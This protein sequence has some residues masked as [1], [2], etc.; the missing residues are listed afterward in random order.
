[1]VVTCAD[2]LGAEQLYEQRRLPGAC[3][4]TYGLEEYADVRAANLVALNGSQYADLHWWHAPK[5]QLMLRVPGAHNVRNALATLAVANWCGVSFQ[6]ALNSLHDFS[7]TA[8]RFEYKGTARGVTV[9][10]DY[11]HHPTKVQATLDAARHRYPG[12]RIWAVFQPHTY[13]RTKQLLAEFAQSFAA[14]DQVIVTD[15]YAAREADDGSVNA[16][17]VVA[18]SPHPH[19]QYIGGLATVADYLAEQIRSG[20]IVVIMGA[21]DS[22]RI[23]EM[24]LERL[25]RDA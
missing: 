1:L 13:S 3:W 5:G 17:D 15:I 8:R 4:I 16:Q 9:I 7:G 25:K 2:D 23:G 22:D 24:L 10:D 19:V 20:D 12:Q 18:A 11:A 21:G 14:A 6:T